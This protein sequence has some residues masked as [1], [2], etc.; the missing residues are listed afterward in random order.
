MASTG[1]MA[2]NV[3][4]MSM[5][6]TISA[7]GGPLAAGAIIKASN[8][9]ALMWITAGAAVLMMGLLLRL[10]TAQATSSASQ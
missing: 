2:G 4:T 8:G 3:S 10:D 9:D 1:T 6:Y 5:V 7:V